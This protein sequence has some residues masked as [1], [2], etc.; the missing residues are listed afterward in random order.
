M[1]H[2]WPQTSL[3]PSQFYFGAVEKGRL[4]VLEEAYQRWGEYPLGESYDNPLWA[5]FI[6]GAAFDS[7]R[8]DLIEVRL[9]H[10]LMSKLNRVDPFSNRSL[11]AALTWLGP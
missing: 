11:S 5:R 3:L 10:A 7:G 2:S 9:L 4:D 1:P 8:N 6:L